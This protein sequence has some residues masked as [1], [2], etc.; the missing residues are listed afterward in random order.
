M[1]TSSCSGLLIVVAAFVVFGA[2]CSSAEQRASATAQGPR[3]AAS[4]TKAAIEIEPNGPADVVRTFYNNL[5]E[6]RVREAI[7]LT[8]LRPAV[9]GLTEAEL[10]EFAV[11][12]ANLGASI[13]KDIEINGEI[14]TGDAAVVTAGL[15]DDEG[16]I[17]P[18]QVKLRRR[19]STWIIK[20]VD[21]AAEAR[22]RQEGR[23]YFRNLRIQTHEDEARKMLERIAKAQM[24]HALQ[25]GGK[26]ADIDDLVSAGL[27]PDDVRSST[28][29]GYNYKI[30]L[31]AD[32][33]DFTAEATPAYYGK[34]GRMSFLLKKDPNGTPRVIGSDNQG[35][36]LA[37][38]GTK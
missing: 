23:Q 31:S 28:S 11:D 38:A 1:N 12:F 26:Y 35:R 36:P 9:D 7:L 22:I 30:D 13:P 6:K 16:K 33:K 10:Q 37:A 29:T 24:V 20:T 32:G 3:A 15:P 27:L 21:E 5:R 19:D 8:D 2:S 25:N 4:K 18:Q 17:N 14:V 34:S